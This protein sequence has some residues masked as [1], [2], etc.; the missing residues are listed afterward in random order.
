MS[1][2]NKLK[3]TH[4]LCIAGH[5]LSTKNKLDTAF[6][7]YLKSLSGK[8]VLEN[9]IAKLQAEIIHKS[10]ELCKEFPRCT[11]INISFYRNGGNESFLLSGFYYIDFK[12]WDARLTIFN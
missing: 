10:Q 5:S 7:A 1:S 4:Y 6:Q 3:P 11:P 2:N 12:I 8:L 9:D